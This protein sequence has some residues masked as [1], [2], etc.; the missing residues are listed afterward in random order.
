MGNSGKRAVFACLLF[1]SFASATAWAEYPDRRIDFVAPF[2]A[3]GYADSVSRLI[4]K[5][6]GERLHVPVV[7]LNKPGAAGIVAMS[8]VSIAPADGYTLLLGNNSSD[9]I[10]P[11]IHKNMAVDPAKA[12]RSVILV[13]NTPDLIAVSNEVKANTL[14]ELIALAKA[15]PGKLSFGTPGVGTTGHL[16]G[17]LF[18]QAAHVDMRH[19]PYA[20][21]QQALTDLVAGRIQV[22]FDNASTLAPLVK[23][24]RIRALAVTD[25]R[26]SRLLP[27]VPTAA[28]AGLP[29]FEVS[30]WVGVEVRAG[31]PDAVVATL[32]KA[33]AA[34]I[35]TDDFKSKMNGG[36][37]MGGS[38]ED[39]D[40]LIRT[41]R[42]KWAGVTRGLNLVVD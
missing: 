39:F 21:T 26:R 36:D 20:G 24:H 28:E 15:N 22:T 4:A 1:L 12:F 33:I 14:R 25:K 5:G 37:V 18:N 3:G 8:A 17:E 41:D 19:I 6:L 23:D 30:G 7:V 35:A 31:T 34:V 29:D 40:H 13:V 32:N 9:T 42:A 16:A 2:A 10:N 11:N 27:D 38:P